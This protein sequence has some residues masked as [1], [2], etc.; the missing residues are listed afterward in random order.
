MDDAR[1]ER[2]EQKLDFLIA[3]LA[4][5]APLLERLKSSSLGKVVS[6]G[7]GGRLRGR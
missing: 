3:T 6:F 4:S 1:L 7:S 2:I 5:F